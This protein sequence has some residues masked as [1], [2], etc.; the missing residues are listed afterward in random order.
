MFARR[1]TVVALVA[2]GALVAVLLGC[3]PKPPCPVPP[4]DV[5]S[6]Q[7][8]TATANEALSKAQADRASLEKNL[9]A[10]QATLESLKGKPEELQKEL[11]NLKK[12]SGR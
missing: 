4:S 11:D 9:A 8:Q 3:G 6:V 5:Q 12:G 2:L 7:S 10:K 1:S